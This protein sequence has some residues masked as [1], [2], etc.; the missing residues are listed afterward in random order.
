MRLQITN[1]ESGDVIYSC[2]TYGDPLS[3][4]KIEESGAE[5]NHMKRLMDNWWASLSQD[6]KE[7]VEIGMGSGAYLISVKA[8]NAIDEVNEQSEKYNVE[9][10]DLPEY[11]PQTSERDY[12]K[13]WDDP[14]EA[15]G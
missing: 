14:L 9:V 1:I 5:L 4:T 7:L 15:E 6:E 12:R 8:I 10:K 11:K 2:R 3:P 13:F